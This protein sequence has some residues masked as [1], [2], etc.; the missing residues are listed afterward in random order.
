MRRRKRHKASQVRPGERANRVP[1]PIE[2]PLRLPPLPREFVAL[3]ADERVAGKV[4]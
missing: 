4:K 2:V 1:P 3:R